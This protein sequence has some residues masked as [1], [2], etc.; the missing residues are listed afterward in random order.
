MQLSS[1]YLPLAASAGHPGSV[2]S[3]ATSS[4]CALNGFSV[5]LLPTITAFFSSLSPAYAPA[6]KRQT[7]EFAPANRPGPS[8]SQTATDDV[9]QKVKLAC[10][11]VSSWVPSVR[12][13]SDVVATIC[14]ALSL[15]RDVNQVLEGN[16]GGKR[17][18]TP[19]RIPVP[20]SATLALVALDNLGAAAAVP[21]PQQPRPDNQTLGNGSVSLPIEVCDEDTMNSIGRSASLPSNAHYRQTRDLDG[22]KLDVN[23]SIVFDGHYDG[24]NHIIRNQHSCLFDHL[25]GTVKNLQLTGARITGDGKDAAIVVCKMD[26]GSIVEDIWIGNGSV[27]THG[28]AL[29]GL[30]SANRTGQSNRVSRIEIHNASVVTHADAALAGAVAGQCH[31]VTEQVAVHHTRLKTHGRG[32]H[33]GLV[34]GSVSG[35][36]ESFA[37]TCSQV[38]TAG[39][40]AMAGMG[41][42]V[43][44]GGQLKGMTV[45]NGSV[46]T[47]GNGSD[48]G[49]G[50]GRMQGDRLQLINI[51]TLYTKVHTTGRGASGGI[52]AGYMDG[53]G[54]L[55]NITGVQSEVATTGN[56]ANAGFGAG[57]IDGFH[58]LSGLTSVN[59]TIRSTGI[60]SRASLTGNMAGGGTAV[61]LDTLTEHTLVNS[62]FKDDAINQSLRDSFCANADQRLVAPNCHI[63]RTALPGNCAPVQ[64]ASSPSLTA[65][66]VTCN[67]AASADVPAVAPTNSSGNHSLVPSSVDPLPVSTAAPMLAGLSANA[68]GGIAAGSMAFVIG[69]C[70]VA[71]CCYHSCHSKDESMAEE[72]DDDLS[73]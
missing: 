31:G 47:T 62:D 4:D 25:R 44:V 71:C 72:S 53:I 52:G 66:P 18:S 46:S 12:V 37:S 14:S 6:H 38:A 65:H 22:T 41:A 42:G 9:T 67:L 35:R 11:I 24:G 21:A 28:P 60:P 51:N 19:V 57:T 58:Q 20:V 8:G 2:P 1:A 17:P 56:G 13:A 23:R 29:A 54:A 15:S 55:T 27:T 43:L 73:L 10:N 68:I 59:N 5:S 69:A 3:A 70:I 61:A 16:K 36:H 50:A 39:P 26:D 64:F 7:P 30:V 45:V 48:A 34:G 63:N 49:V 40:G 33:A 32:A